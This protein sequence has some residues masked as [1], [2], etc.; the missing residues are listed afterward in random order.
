MSSYLEERVSFELRK[1]THVKAI[2]LSVRLLIALHVYSFRFVQS[3]VPP[4][5][6]YKVDQG[7]ARCLG[8]CSSR[9]RREIFVSIGRQGQSRTVRLIC[10]LKFSL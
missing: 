2:I 7:S 8:R 6:A 9:Q 5:I 4:F 10:L 1:Y 3:G